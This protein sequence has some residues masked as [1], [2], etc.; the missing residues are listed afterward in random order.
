MR[1][2]PQYFA[3]A[4]KTLTPFHGKQVRSSRELQSFRKWT[5]RCKSRVESHLFFTSSVLSVAPL[6]LVGSQLSVFTES[7]SGFDRVIAFLHVLPMHR[8]VEEANRHAQIAQERGARPARHAAAAAPRALGTSLVQAG[9]RVAC[10]GSG[11]CAGLWQPRWRTAA[12]I[13]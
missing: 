7:I 1:R 8:G 5:W 3:E 4:F 10:Q 13:L 11:L 9:Q 12:I 2:Y 6:R